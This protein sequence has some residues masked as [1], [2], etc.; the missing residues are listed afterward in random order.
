MHK[1]GHDAFIG[2]CIVCLLLVA[3]TAVASATTAEDEQ[4]ADIQNAIE[5]KGAKWTAGKTAVSGLS[6]EEKELLFGLEID[7]LPA[8]IPVISP[9][10]RLRAIPYG[11]FDW[12]NKDGQNWM[13]S[14][15]NQGSCGSCWAFAAVGAVEAVINIERN[16]PDIDIDLSEQLAETL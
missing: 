10:T 13:T 16:D 7:S 11:S 1:S 3:I 12:R 6:A 2:L 4:L 15:K 14:V 8:D 5:E 9:P